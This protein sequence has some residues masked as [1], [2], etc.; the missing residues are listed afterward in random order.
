MRERLTFNIAYKTINPNNDVIV[1]MVTIKTT[2]L[3]LI[4][5]GKL[6]LNT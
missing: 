5:K 6:K 1:Q 2:T 3:D 4:S